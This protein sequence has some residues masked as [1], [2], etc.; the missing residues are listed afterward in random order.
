[1]ANEYYKLYFLRFTHII[2][3]EQFY[4]VG[5]TKHSIDKRFD[6][7]EYNNY[8]IEE[9]DVIES[10]HLWVAIEEDKFLN[11]FKNYQYAPKIKFGGY[12]ECFKEEIYDVMFK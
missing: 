5:K 3:N 10:T 7:P 11:N 8:N 6:K 9:I 4:K 2:T 12:T 1:L